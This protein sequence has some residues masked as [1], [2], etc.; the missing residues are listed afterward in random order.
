[1]ILEDF[2]IENKIGRQ[3]KIDGQKKGRR[4]SVLANP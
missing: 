1:M 4:H 3:W 2:L